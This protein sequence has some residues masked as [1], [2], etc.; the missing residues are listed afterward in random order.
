MDRALAGLSLIFDNHLLDLLQVDSV[1]VAR[2]NKTN[3]NSIGTLFPGQRMD[4]V[5]QP[6]LPTSEKQSHMRVRLDQEYEQARP[7][8]QQLSR[9]C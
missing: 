1:D 4:F 2:S 3:R 7:A 6:L 9:G 8:S 5:L